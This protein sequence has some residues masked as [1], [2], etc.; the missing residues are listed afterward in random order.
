MMSD[1]PNNDS[2][3]ALSES[4]NRVIKQQAA[5]HREMAAR[6]V[7]LKRRGDE[8]KHRKNSD[9]QSAEKQ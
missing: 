6:Q 5:D 9:E 1:L 8:K 4:L 7:Q 2:L 3:I